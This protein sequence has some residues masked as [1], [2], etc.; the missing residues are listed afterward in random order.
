MDVRKDQGHNCSDSLDDPLPL[1]RLERMKGVKIRAALTVALAIGLLLIAVWTV[2]ARSSDLSLNPQPATA[3][4]DALDESIVA[5]HSDR[6]L[7]YSRPAAV[8]AAE[9]STMDTQSAISV[10]AYFWEPL[11]LPAGI[12]ASEVYGFAVHPTDALRLFIGTWSGLY[13]SADAGQSWTQVA[14]TTFSFVGNVAIAASNPL[15]MYARSWK[16]YRSDNGGVSWNEIPSPPSMCSFVIAPSDA[17][18][19]YARTCSSD[20]P[21]V[22]RSDDGGQTWITPTLTFTTTL[23]KLAVAP[24]DPNVLIGADFSQVFRS[25]NGGTTWITAPIGTRYFG[26]PAFDPQ[27]PYTLYLGH[28][29]GLLRSTD[30][31]A[32]WQDS[33]VAREFSDVAASPFKNQQ[34]LGGNDTASWLIDSSGTAW[35]ATAW[36]APLPLKS[37]WRSV[38]DNRAIYART[39]QAWWRFI[40]RTLSQPQQVF[41]PIVQRGN[42]TPAFPPA[43]QQAL[44]RMNVYRARVGVMPLRLHPAI[45]A[46]AQNHATYHMLNYA[47]SSAWANGPHGEVAGKPGYTGKWP[48]DRLVAAGYPS[49][50]PWSGGSEV[51]HFIGDPIASVDGWMATIYHRVIPLDP[52]ALYTGYGNGRNNHTAVDV[53]DFGGGPTDN[54]LWSSAVPYPLAYPAN[55]QIDV[56]ISW[57]GGESPNPL[58]PGA[59]RPVGYPFTL[60][61]VGGILQVTSIQLRK[62]GQIV[63]VHPNPSDCSVFN[64]YAL[65][66]V[67]PLQANT[68]YTVQAQGSVGGIAFDRTW[69]FTTGSTPGP[70]LLD[71]EQPI[72]PPLRSP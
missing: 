66:A 41:L 17:N 64:C 34:A 14:S 62:G 52:A 7:L 70:T 63:A 6:R 12:R 60:Q 58:P 71:R 69:T 26:Q 20:S 51:M 24:D 37:V 2:S 32:T 39:D 1:L 59:S 11:T 13:Q 33:G 57:D 36:N 22:L 55:G 28:W 42:L 31:G 25:A 10:T 48:F 45:V 30:R 38:S 19:V 8:T 18:R 67:Q 23:D 9:S 15:R 65:I 61:G 53:M 40:Q 72:G 4:T 56:P 54:G 35:Q 27:P 47:D 43:A 5:G 68:T 29:T 44:D 46:A 49:T 50:Y 3:L 16:L 21:A